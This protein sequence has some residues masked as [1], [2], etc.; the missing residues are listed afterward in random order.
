MERL[1]ERY[2]ALCHSR[3]AFLRAQ[4][5]YQE[6]LNQVD[7]SER[8]AYVASLV[9]HFELFYEMLWKFFKAYLFEVYGIE[10]VGSKTIFRACCEQRLIS[11]VNLDQLLEIVEIRNNTIHMYDEIAALELASSI[12]GYYSAMDTLFQTVEAT[13]TDA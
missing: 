5:L 7:Q 10:T 4:K 8:E 12:I 3:A 9:K 1:K 2:A 11:D 6:K 13:F